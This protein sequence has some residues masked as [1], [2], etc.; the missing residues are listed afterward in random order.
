MERNVSHPAD[1]T[2]LLA[3]YRR[4]AADALHKTAL[5]KTVAKKGPRAIDA[6]VDT[7]AR[8]VKRRDAFAAKLAKLGVT[9]QD[10]TPGTLA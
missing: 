5:I 6:A 3:T 8:A 4:A 7:A 10:E 9:V 2:E 1:H